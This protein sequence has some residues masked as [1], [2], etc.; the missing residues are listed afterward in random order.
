MLC[1][2]CLASKSGMVEGNDGAK[3]KRLFIEGREGISV[4]CSAANVN[5]ELVM[6]ELGLPPRSTCLALLCSTSVLPVAV[7]PSC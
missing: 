2:F 7:P 6:D 5:G 1:D 3:L 4:V